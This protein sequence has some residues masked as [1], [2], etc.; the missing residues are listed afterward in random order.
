MTGERKE[1]VKIT[2]RSMFWAFV[3]V[4]LI[5]CMQATLPVGEVVAVG[6]LASV[7]ILVAVIEF[8]LREGFVFALVSVMGAFAGWF[9]LHQELSDLMQ[10]KAMAS[11][12]LALLCT[13]LIAGAIDGSSR[14]FLMTGH[15]FGLLWVTFLNNPKIT[16]G[17]SVLLLFV[18]A[19][20]RLKGLRAAKRPLP[21]AS[22]T[23]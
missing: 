9:F 19:V 4:V 8:W 1:N 21:T 16:A 3:A 2:S 12:T 23:T 15:M 13:A 7:L 22:T 6:M 11:I 18:W 5:A 14:F 17:L 10:I 20:L